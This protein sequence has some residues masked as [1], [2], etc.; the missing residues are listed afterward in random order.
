MRFRGVFVSRASLFFCSFARSLKQGAPTAL[1]SEAG[2]TA[3][4]LDHHLTVLRYNGR[5]NTFKLFFDVF[6]SCEIRVHI[7]SYEALRKFEQV[8]CFVQTHEHVTVSH[9]ISNGNEKTWI[10]KL[11]ARTTSQELPTHPPHG[12]SHSWSWNTENGWNSK[13][14]SALWVALLCALLLR[15]GQVSGP[16]ITL[17]ASCD[18]A[19]LCMTRVGQLQNMHPHLRAHGGGDLLRPR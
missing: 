14:A 17:T 7:D 15:V 1:A 13:H 9:P 8:R 5:R 11:R 10:Q 2:C 12:S 18:V 3:P 4:S 19:V 6:L 16:F